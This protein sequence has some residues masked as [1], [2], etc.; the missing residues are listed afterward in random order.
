MARFQFLLFFP[1]LVYEF[2]IAGK[3]RPVVIS[4]NCML[5]ELDPKLGFL[6]A[7]IES[8]WKALSGITGC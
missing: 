5:V 3:G 1:I 7:E 2:V 6:D 4:G 8:W